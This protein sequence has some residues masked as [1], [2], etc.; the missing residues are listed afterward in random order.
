[1][2]PRTSRPPRSIWRPERGND[3]VLC[4]LWGQGGKPECWL[5][6][7]VW[8]GGTLLVRAAP[9]PLKHRAK[10]SRADRFGRSG[11]SAER[12]PTGYK[13]FGFP[14]TCFEFLHTYLVMESAL[15]KAVFL[16]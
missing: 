1:M 10:A 16:R 9:K 6:K 7:R 3:G 12:F 8:D 4:Q 2:L 13:Y 11:R 15:T 14:P 5:E